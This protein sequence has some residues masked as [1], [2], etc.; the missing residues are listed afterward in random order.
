MRVPAGG[1]FPP[2]LRRLGHGA[3]RTVDAWLPGTGNEA[4]NGYGA[5]LRQTCAPGGSPSR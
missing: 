1:S 5:G 4:G 2:T 3:G